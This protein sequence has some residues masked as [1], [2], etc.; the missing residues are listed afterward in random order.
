M[1]TRSLLLTAT[2]AAGSAQASTSVLIADAPPP[3]P[4]AEDPA[5][6]YDGTNGITGTHLYA[7]LTPWR[8][9][10]GDWLDADNVA[11]G[12]KPFGETLLATNQAGPFTVDVTSLVKQGGEPQLC[13]R[14]FNT[15]AMGAIFQFKSR[16]TG[17]GPVLKV[18]YDDDELATIPVMY[19]SECNPSTA[20]ETGAATTITV[21]SNGAYLR[22]PQPI[23][24]VKQAMLVLNGTIN[25]GGKLRIFK[26][27]LH[28][29]PPPTETFTLKDDPRVFYETE[30]FDGPETPLF[31]Q[32]QLF[33]ATASNP[34]YKNP[35]L[36]VDI[37]GGQKAFQ[38]T[39]DPASNSVLSASLAFPDF[40]E[41]DEAA[42]EFDIRL[43]P[44]M[45]DGIADAFKLFAGFA[46][47]TKNDD[48]Y[49]SQWTKRASDP[50]AWAMKNIPGRAGSMIA[51]NSG[52]RAHGDDGWSHRFDCFDT[53]PYPH[54]LHKRWL[55]TQYTYWPGQS[56]AFGDQWSWNLNN[57][58][59]LT[60]EWYTITERMKINT[61][62]ATNYQQDAEFDGYINNHL[63]IR[64]RN[65]YLRTTDTPIIAKP[66]Y[67][68]KSKLAIGRI[69]IATY[70]GGTA[71]ALSR[72]SFQIRNFRAAK[73]A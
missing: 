49:F 9:K 70:H 30:A 58:M 37:G 14:P 47:S 71:H 20:Y 4:G 7:R 45:V 65:Y 32:A 33:G 68:V 11:Q 40:E 72:C 31:L 28:R 48:D 52:A 73:F 24:P 17:Q 35:N 53:P 5:L 46:A 36:V 43:M 22:F 15:S 13:L 6:I 41:A 50:P 18:T 2:N 19:D 23:K 51:G 62:L 60:N 10:G 27:A 38:A 3:D 54:P 59:L 16:E 26:F 69:W 25:T 57:S 21:G 56:D 34:T 55:L 44:D 29:A 12:S 63:A 67:N 66:P 8:N 64:R 39:F 42:V 61:C 1:T